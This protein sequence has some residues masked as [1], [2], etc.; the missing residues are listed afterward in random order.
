MES[1][2][3]RAP[4]ATDCADRGVADC[5][6]EPASWRR[7]SLRHPQA[8]LSS[9]DSEPARKTAQNAPLGSFGCQF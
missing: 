7:R 2:G 1:L 6:L 5:G 8:A 9:A 4:R 3:S